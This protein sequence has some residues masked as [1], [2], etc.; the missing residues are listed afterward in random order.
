MQLGVPKTGAAAQGKPKNMAL[1]TRCDVCSVHFDISRTSP[2]PMGY[3]SGEDVAGMRFSVLEAL[4][5][6]LH[7]A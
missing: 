4:W 1:S 6:A 5:C 3:V 2:I 7:A